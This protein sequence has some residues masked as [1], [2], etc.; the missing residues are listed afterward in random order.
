MTI[1]GI[2]FWSRYGVIL[3]LPVAGLLVL[4]VLLIWRQTPW[5]VLDAAPF[6]TVTPAQ[7]ME[8][9]AGV[10]WQALP[11]IDADR[12]HQRLL[13]LFTRKARQLTSDYGEDWLTL[14]LSLPPAD[15]LL[16]DKL[17]LWPGWQ[18]QTLSLQPAGDMWAV[19]LRWQRLLRGQGVARPLLD[20]P[21]NS[22]EVAIWRLHASSVPS[23]QEYGP[24]T[25]TDTAEARPNWQYLGYVLDPQ[26]AGAWLAAE[27]NDEQAKII[28]F[29]RRGEV[30]Q[31]WKVLHIAV[32]SLY[33]QRG[34]N[35]WVLANCAQL[36]HCH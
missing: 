20:K 21:D 12:L 18:L 3:V 28:R 1:S 11:D 5:F 30:W 36:E 29:M 14:D 9:N 23:A 16:L 25:N 10:H 2:P 4:L 35:S 26:G 31:G 7:L 17:P 15:L 27:A 33:L 6:S 22:F 19:S 34:A 13:Q 8:N 24:V 32:D